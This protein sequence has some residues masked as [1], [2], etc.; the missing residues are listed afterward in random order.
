MWRGL[1]FACICGSLWS[2]PPSSGVRVDAV[3][4]QP[5]QKDAVSGVL[6]QERQLIEV[7]FGGETLDPT[8]AEDVQHYRLYDT[9]DTLDTLDDT[10]ANPV[11]A[12]YDAPANLVVLDFGA[13]LVTLFS[14]GA[15][16]RLEIGCGQSLPDPP[17]FMTSDPGDHWAGALNLGTLD[18]LSFSIS[19]S[20]DAQS[21]HLQRP[22]SDDDPGH[23][24][25]THVQGPDGDPGVFTIT[26]GFPDAYGE[27]PPGTALVNQITDAQKNRAREIFLMLNM[28]LGATFAESTDPDIAV[29]TGDMRVVDPTA[30][31]PAPGGQKGAAGGGMI[32]LDQA[33]TWD[34]SFLG[35]WYLEAMRLTGYLLGFYDTLTLPPPGM[36]GAD[37]GLGYG[38][39]PEAVFPG[40][41]DQVHGQFMYRP[42]G[43]DMD[44]YRFEVQSVGRVNAE[45]I[46]Q[47]SETQPNSLDAM[48]R[49]YQDSGD[50]IF[51]L[52]QN[53]DYFSDDPALCLLIDE[54]GTYYLVVSI[55]ANDQYQAGSPLTGYGGRSQGSYTLRLS[56][57]P[58]CVGITDQY[59]T[60]L[61]GDGDHQPG[62]DFLFWFR[63]QDE[64]HTRYVDKT[65]DPDGGQPLGTL[66]NPYDSPSTALAAASYGDVVTLVGNGGADG[67]LATTDDNVAYE[68]GF[69]TMN[70]PLADGERLSVPFGVFLTV[71]PG[72][73]IKLHKAY[74]SVGSLDSATDR[75]ES[76]IQFRGTPT[77][78]VILGSYKD[79]TLGQDTDPLTTTPMAG[80]WGGMLFTSTLDREHYRTDP[81]DRG[82]FLQS[83]THTHL[84]YGG[85]TVNINAIA[86]LVTPIHVEE[87]RPTLIS[88]T[89]SASADAALTGTPDSFREDRFRDPRYQ[90]SPFEPHYSRKGPVIY[91]NATADNTVNGLRIDAQAG[92]TTCAIWDDRDVVHVLD[93]NLWITGQPA[94]PWI[95][96]MSLEWEAR[97]SPGL[98]VTPGMVIKLDECGVLT[99]FGAHLLAEGVPGEPIIWTSLMDDDFGGC[100]TYDTNNDGGL[101]VPTRGDWGGLYAG[102]ASRLNLAHA[103]LYFAGG[104]V[105]VGGIFD[106]LNPVEVHQAYARIDGNEFRQC[107]HGFDGSASSRQGLGEN[108]EATVFVRG[109]QPVII[110][111]TL[112]QNAGPAISIDL[113]AM[114]PQRLEDPGNETGYADPL[115]R[116]RDNFGPLIRENTLE[117]NGVNGLLV[118]SGTLN[119]HSVWDDVDI[120][121]VLMDH[122]YSHNLHTFGGIRF[123]AGPDAPLVVKALGVDAGF[124]ATGASSSAPDR[125]GG[126]LHVVDRS[127]HAVVFTSLLDDSVGAGRDTQLQPQTDTNNDGVTT[128]PAVGDWMGLISDAQ[129]HHLDFAVFAEDE[130]NDPSDSDVNDDIGQAMWLGAV[131]P[132]GPGDAILGFDVH[133]FLHREDDVDVYAFSAEGGTELWLDV[134]ATTFALDTV[135]ELLDFNGQLLARSDNSAAE[136]QGTQQPNGIAQTFSAFDDFSWNPQDGGMW[137]LVPGTPGQAEALYIRVRSWG[138]DLD[139]DM[140]GGET[141]GG[142]DLQV[143][144]SATQQFPG[145]QCPQPD[146]I[147]PPVGGTFC[148]NGE[149]QMSIQV[150]TRQRFATWGEDVQYQWYKDDVAIPGAQD[151]VLTLDPASADDVGI[152]HVA[153]RDACGEWLSDPVAWTLGTEITLTPDVQVQGWAPIIVDSTF[154]CGTAGSSWS[155]TLRQ[156]SE[157]LAVDVS[158]LTLD[159]LLTATSDIDLLITE[160]PYTGSSAS[161]RVLVPQ[162]SDPDGDGCN[163]PGD[164]LFLAERWRQPLLNDPSGDGFV[165]IID[166]LLVNTTD[167]CP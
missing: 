115:T 111:N 155:W 17:T 146:V 158:T 67:E 162:N 10:A 147:D 100:S 4:P 118:R 152:Y 55:S 51:S 11:S 70:I 94:G 37:A 74:L 116:Y 151:N 114:D 66:I 128:T 109:C 134:D 154:S 63:T 71:E 28:Y 125:V 53:D 8:S 137:V 34:D 27:Y 46:A 40:K 121:H 72:V 166:F 84:Q 29:I 123:V 45:I 148:A 105:D 91:G 75:S 14:P 88:N 76:A 16:L 153:F 89:I 64:A 85:G 61:D 167:G 149:I 86:R 73:I 18:E 68:I 143:R 49:L 126:M 59:Q 80:D 161:A 122:I 157:L 6:M 26:Y 150:Q 129:A 30:P 124:T 20:L 163:T 95:H 136:A 25:E 164:L 31:P 22:G 47:R 13:D 9:K 96:P 141:R 113:N 101:C 98:V 139:G 38:Q 48:L 110:R 87:M 77:W 35:D 1:C 165:D 106:E 21:H 97:L 117:D 19:A 43:G 104:T 103:A 60:P 90:F 33:E 79:E 93:E 144:Q 156:T 62:G 69:D 131:A 41:H 82:I 130:G 2:I 50:S 15:T 44:V 112:W 54:P 140:H 81:E 12:S 42:E 5:V 108:G 52:G 3:V 138:P 145:V 78:P 24:I 102:Q 119:T 120:V 56:H 133:G 65:H 7:W 142:Y 32:I 160:G 39:T 92:L 23:E 135:L 159:T 127:G 83:M 58:T 57:R 36:M 107:D 99:R 132:G